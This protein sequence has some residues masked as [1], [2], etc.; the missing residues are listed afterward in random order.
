MRGGHSNDVENAQLE[1][2]PDA[3]SVLLGSFVRSDT[4]TNGSFL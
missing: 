3:M 2:L 1:K 4:S